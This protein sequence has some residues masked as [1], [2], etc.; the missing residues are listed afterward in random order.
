MSNNC[1]FGVM[2]NW[3]LQCHNCS[4]NSVIRSSRAGMK[5]RYCRRRINFAFVSKPDGAAR[6]WPSPKSLLFIPVFDSLLQISVAS[7]CLIYVDCNQL[8]S[9]KLHERADPFG[10]VVSRP[11]SKQHNLSEDP[12]FCS[13]LH[14][15]RCHGRAA[16]VGRLILSLA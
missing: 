3:V 10:V 4:Q 5:Y 2:F 12:R 13:R 11:S 7:I 16:N 6:R 8:T 1:L 15:V 14:R 9:A